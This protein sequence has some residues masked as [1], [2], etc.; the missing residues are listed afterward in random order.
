MLP[1]RPAGRAG[2]IL[3]PVLPQFRFVSFG[4]RYPS[5]RILQCD[6]P[7]SLGVVLAIPASQPS[8]SPA[9]NAQLREG[10]ERLT[11]WSPGKS[12]LFS[13]ELHPESS[14]A[15]SMQTG[16]PFIPRRYVGTG[17]PKSQLSARGTRATPWLAS[18]G[19]G[20]YQLAAS[21]RE[22][23]DKTQLPW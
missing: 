6:A 4:P 22:N 14:Q 18:F 8:G 12:R 16:L 9:A 5:G 2:S 11:R 17:E 1:H 20:R 19:A 3:L 13:M 7:L 21:L 15:I 23:R 10:E